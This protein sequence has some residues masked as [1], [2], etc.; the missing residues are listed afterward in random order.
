MLPISKT[1]DIHQYKNSQF[2]SSAAQHNAA[3]NL[4]HPIAVTFVQNKSKK[5]PYISIHPSMDRAAARAEQQRIS[6]QE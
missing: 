3:Q 1:T 6:T 4:I 2:R 5:S